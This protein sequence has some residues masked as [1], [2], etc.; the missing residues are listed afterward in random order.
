MSEEKTLAEMATVAAG[1]G[2]EI[3]IAGKPANACPFCGCVMFKDKTIAHKSVTIRYVQCRNGACGKRFVSRQSPEVLIR[4][5]GE[6]SSGGTK[7]LTVFR[8]TG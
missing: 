8:E 4:E 5:V 3:F 6:D 2:Q 1:A 7:G